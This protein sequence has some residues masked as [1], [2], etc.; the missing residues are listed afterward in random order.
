LFLCPLLFLLLRLWFPPFPLLGSLVR[1]LRLRFPR[2]L[3]LG[4]VSSW[5]ARLFRVGC[6]WVVLLVLMRSSVARF[7]LLPFFR[8]P[9]L[10]LCVWVVRPL[11]L[12]LLPWFARLLLLVG[13]WLLFLVVLVLRVLLRRGLFAVVVRG[14]GVRWLWRLVWVVL[15]WLWWKV[16]ARLFPRLLLWLVGFR[17]WGRA[18]VSRFGGLCLLF[19][20][21]LVPG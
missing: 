18:W 9:L 21:L 12:V 14:L 2:F 10:R 11:L 4:F 13:F 8:F 15:P 6:W 5:V 1:V 16:L 19:L 20:L 17:V 3:L 7:L